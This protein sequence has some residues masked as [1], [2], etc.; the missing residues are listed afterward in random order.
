TAVVR[1]DG[2]VI[3]SS[4]TAVDEWLNLDKK[5]VQDLCYSPQ[6]H[7]AAL[8]TLGVTKLN[9][10]MEK[11]SGADVVEGLIEKASAKANQLERSVPADAGALRSQLN[12]LASQMEEAEGSKIHLQNDL[13]LAENEKRSA[14]SLV[15]AAEATLKQLEQQELT[16]K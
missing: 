10:L 6:T 2:V 11:V 8:L 16:W 1:L 13:E 12:D 7:T 5:T 15:E 14:E 4:S 3:A 9:A